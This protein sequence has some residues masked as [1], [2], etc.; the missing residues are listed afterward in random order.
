MNKSDDE[1]MAARERR[2][3]L[4]LERLFE[5]VRRMA[6]GVDGILELHV[7]AFGDEPPAPPTYVRA[8]ETAVMTRT[9]AYI[10]AAQS[11]IR[12]E[13]WVPVDLLVCLLR[14]LESR[15]NAR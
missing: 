1:I 8:A 3:D 2:P 10:H 15:V 6:E 9:R 7:K 5:D 12:H 11:D 4:S 13:T 14:A